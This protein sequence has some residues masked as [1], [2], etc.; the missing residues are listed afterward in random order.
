[1]CVGT[2]D[3]WNRNVEEKTVEVQSKTLLYI[4][5]DMTQQIQTYAVHII[6]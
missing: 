5:N 3:F 1:M 4:Q 2:S 6:Y